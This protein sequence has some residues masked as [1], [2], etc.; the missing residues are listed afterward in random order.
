MDTNEGDNMDIVLP[1]VLDDGER[2]LVLVTH[3]EITF[4]SNDGKRK[5]WIEDGMQHLRPNGSGKFKIDSKFLCFA[6]FI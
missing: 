1:P 4:D 3:D 5:L 2:K 6:M